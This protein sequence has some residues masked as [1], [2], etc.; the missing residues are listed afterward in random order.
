MNESVDRRNFSVIINHWYEFSCWVHIDSGTEI[1]NFT[2]T[3][4]SGDTKGNISAPI[5][6]DPTRLSFIF[7]ADETTTDWRLLI[8]K[9][10][11]ATRTFYLD[12]ISIVHRPDYLTLRQLPDNQEPDGSIKYNDPT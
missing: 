4:A 6:T 2:V 1:I 3:N 12:N 11:D 8:P 5:T 10:H 7:R 9:P